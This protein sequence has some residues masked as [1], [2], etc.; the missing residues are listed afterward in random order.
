M[1]KYILLADSKTKKII[2]EMNINTI[3]NTTLEARQIVDKILNTQKI[4]NQRNNL[5]GTDGIFYYSISKFKILIII[6]VNKDYPSRMVFQLIDEINQEKIPQ[7]V[8]NNGELNNLGKKSLN[9]I[10]DKYQSNTINK[11]QDQ[12]DE[13]RLEMNENIRNIVNNV[14]D[15]QTLDNKA[16]KIK[17]NADIF[18]KDAVNLKRITWW[19]NFKLTIIIVSIVIALVLVIVLPIVLR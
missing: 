13:I 15:A 9:N 3:P 4:I 1:I 2:T 16:E 10:L 12:V 7:Q 8:N 14:E 17:D 18:K 6:Q 19:K 11:I 5:Y